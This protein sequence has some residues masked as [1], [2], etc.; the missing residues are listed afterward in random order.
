MEQPAHP[1]NASA[2][3]QRNTQ[4]IK[5]AHQRTTSEEAARKKE[6]KGQQSRTEER[7]RGEQSRSAKKGAEEARE[8]SKAQ[9]RDRAEPSTHKTA[10]LINGRTGPEHQFLLFLPR[11][12]QLMVEDPIKAPP[13]PAWK[14]MSASSKFQKQNVVR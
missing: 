10:L 12:F 6:R 11:A 7:N 4:R 14:S 5:T 9:Q 8:R 2:A 13:A 1:P 3:H